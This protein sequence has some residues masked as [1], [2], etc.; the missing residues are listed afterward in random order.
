MVAL[1][2][3]YPCSIQILPLCCFL[4]N[5]K[6]TN[7]G[8]NLRPKLCYLTFSNYSRGFAQNLFQVS[9]FWLEFA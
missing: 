5:N 8:K 7:E 9:N 2:P 1:F 4:A 6:L 3:I